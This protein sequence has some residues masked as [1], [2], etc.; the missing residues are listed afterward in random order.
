MGMNTVLG[1]GRERVPVRSEELYS[2]ALEPF[3]GE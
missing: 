2:L 3:V 1:S